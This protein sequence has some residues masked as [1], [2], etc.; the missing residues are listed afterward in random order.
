MTTRRPYEPRRVDVRAADGCP[1]RVGER[2]VSSIREQWLVEDRWWT[3]API[4]RRYFELVL[5]G[6][7]CVVVFRDMNYGGGWYAQR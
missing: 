2:D 3:E 4:R 7:S 5:D 6:G 1:L